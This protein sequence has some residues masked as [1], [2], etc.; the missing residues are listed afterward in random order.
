[1]ASPTVCGRISQWH[2]LNNNN[3]REDPRRIRCSKDK[4]N[5]NRVSALNQEDTQTSINWALVDNFNY[6]NVKKEI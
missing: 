3:N 4:G 1:M 6:F 5:S 2:G